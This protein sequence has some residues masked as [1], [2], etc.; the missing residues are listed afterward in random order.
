M[1]DCDELHLP[2]RQKNHVYSRFKEDFS[3][4]NDERPPTR[5][6]FFQVWNN[7][8][9]N[10]KVRKICKFSKCPE[11]DLI[12]NTIRIN[13][14]AGECS[15]RI[16]QKKK[17]HI[18]FILQE[19]CKYYRKRELAKREPNKYLSLTNDGPTNP[20]TDFPVF[21]L[22]SKTKEVIR[23]SLSWL[24]YENTQPLINWHYWHLQKISLPGLII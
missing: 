21:A 2:Y 15:K 6:M 11:C 8:C 19:R 9:K 3:N 17:E 23:W 12:E 14:N 1:P 5:S 16:L 24:V 10:I 7:Q 18:Q 13:R 4:S 22:L 20:A